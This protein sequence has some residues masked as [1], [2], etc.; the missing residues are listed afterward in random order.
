MSLYAVP[1]DLV[2][3]DRGGAPGKN[4]GTDERLYRGGLDQVRDIVPHALGRRLYFRRWRQVRQ[5]RHLEILQ[6]G[7][8]H[9]I[10]GLPAR[11]NGQ[12][13]EVA[14]VQQTRALRAHHGLRDSLH[15][16]TN[17]GVKHVRKLS[18]CSRPLAR[19]LR[20]L[21]I[22]SSDGRRRLLDTEGGS[23]EK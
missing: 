13:H 4:G 3:E 22:E 11:N 23:L 6:R 10:S 18:R 21:L 9:A 8:I 15:R 19:A 16:Q 7:Q 1:K 20:P 17:A 5:V 2:K 14:P 12:V